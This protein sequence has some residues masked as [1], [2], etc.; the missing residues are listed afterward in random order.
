[1]RTSNS[2]NNRS[3]WSSYLTISQR[4][5]SILHSERCKWPRYVVKQIYEQLMKH[6]GI[7]EFSVL[8]SDSQIVW[9][10]E[11]VWIIEICEL[12]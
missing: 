2:L 3:S 9:H 1:M 12:K 10:I 4:F 7:H 6:P 8:C 5:T 11:E